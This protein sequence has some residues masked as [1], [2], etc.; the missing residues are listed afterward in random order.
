MVEDRTKHINISSACDPFILSRSLLRCDV[1]GCAKHFLCSGNSAVRF[2][3]PDQTKVGQVWFA[4]CV[5]QD[6]ARLN[7]AMQDPALMG[8]MN[9]AGEAGNDLRRATQGNG[10]APDELIEL[11]AF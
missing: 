6:I 9:R 5:E 3:Q 1:T 10:S 8:V 4:L 11:T 7:I 2:H